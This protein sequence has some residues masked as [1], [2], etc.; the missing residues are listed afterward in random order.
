MKHTLRIAVSLAVMG[1]FA[2]SQIALADDDAAA[3]L[4][5][6]KSGIEVIE[7]TV[8]ALK[9]DTNL[10]E[11]PIAISVMNNEEM[12]KRHILSLANLA[13]GSIP[14]L[15][16]AT[17]EA[18]QSALTVGMRGIVPLDANQPAR[19]QG[20]GIYLDGVYLGRQHGLNAQM[21]D[22]ERIEVLKGPQGTL[23][24]RN[25]EGGALSMVSRAPTGEFEGRLT[26]GVGNYG[27]YNES[28]H[29]DFPEVANVSFKLDGAL[30]HQN[31][32]LD[33]PLPGNVG[34]NYSH[35]YGGQVSARWKP[36]DSFTADFSFD[37]GHDENTPYYSQL[38]NYNPR[39][40]TVLPVTQA[41]GSIPAGTI[42][43]LPSIVKVSADRMDVADIGVVQQ[44]S[45]DKTKG[46]KIN[47]A[48]KFDGFELRSISAYRTVSDD[49]WDN[50]GGAHRTAVYVTNANFSRYSLSQMHQH[51]FSEELQAV[52]GFDNIDYVAGLYY[53]T[54]GAGDAAATPN[55]NKWNADGTGYTI[56]DPTPT[57]PGK[58]SLDRASN[59]IAKSVAAYGQ[60]TWT[61][62]EMKDVHLTVGGRETKDDKSG[63]LYL[64]NNAPTNL[65]FN[66]TP[67]HFDPL[68][69]LAYDAA[70]RAHVYLKYA[71]GYRS[72]G[73]SSRSL[74]YRSFGPETVK[75]WE[76][77]AKTE[78]F[79]RMIRL[80]VAAYTMDRTGSQVDFNFFD[81]I[82]N[83]NTLETVNAPGT[84]KIKGLE[85]D[86]TAYLTDNL[87][88]NFSYSY[89]DAKVP[90]TPNPLLAGN[91]IQPVF[92][93]FTPRNAASASVDYVV[94]LNSMKLKFHM[95]G[96]YSDAAYS[97]DSE[98]VKT[99][100]AL[101]FNARL[102]LAEIQ[103]GKNGTMLQLSAWA[104]N[105][106]NEEH[107]YRRSNANGA[108]LGD[109]ANFNPPRTFGVEANFSF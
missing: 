45:L 67:S 99:E 40:L 29:V 84:T 72:G 108:V 104:R 56:L 16:I 76:V 30:S 66:I 35:K 13:D 17:F 9:R 18:R 101:I 39:G 89:S 60:F 96:N 46:G 37:N 83:R 78:W 32:T 70:E 64:V 77:G 22:L 51:Q 5:K 19:E 62:A 58:R 53:F 86:V 21:L 7:I 50:S 55:T 68:V 102:S 63:L 6:D 100:P 44:P 52:G 2:Q 12:E 41:A 31:A 79:D 42:R 1:Y 65:T 69:T 26:T 8:S 103:M 87:S 85:V 4:S 34:W 90:P 92:I 11:T 75:S 98:D 71:S 109:Y 28:L 3:P 95:D 105:M 27:S 82:T 48:W 20:V 97:F 10:Q 24:G 36:S 106:F 59:A 23:F 93:V 80:N 88:A 81:P 15:R 33:N 74:T 47:L 43:A 57:I 54:E 107:I 91:P 25:T 73:A 38:I 49:Q 14:S 61:P 94:P